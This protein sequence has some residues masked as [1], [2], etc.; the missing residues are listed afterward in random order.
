MKYLNGEYYVEVKDH[1]Y[2]IHPTENII[3][4]KRD[5]PKSLRTQYQVQNERQIRRNQKVIKND[6]YQLVVK[7]YPK[8]KQPSIQQQSKFKPPN[9]PS[10]KQNM[11]LEFDKGYYCQNCEYIINKQKHQIDKNVVTQ[12]RDFSTRLNYANK[13]IKEIWMN[14]V[15]TTY[16]TTEGMIDNLQQLKGKTKLKFYK[17]KSN[18]NKE[19]KRKNFQTQEDHFSKNS[20]GLTRIYHEVL[21]LMKFPQTKQQV[22]DMNINYNDLY[23]TVIKTRDENKDIDNQYENDENDYINFHDFITP[24]H[25]IAIKK[26]NEILR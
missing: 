1:R 6:D 23:Y 21:L 2:K 10:C 11:W 12:G 13:K 14:T 19:M 3:L 17:S 9:C 4:R 16:N 7:N 20:E 8:N 24:N 18:Y 25:Y 22:R 5:P 26:N 15:N